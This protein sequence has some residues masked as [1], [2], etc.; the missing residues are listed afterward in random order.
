MLTGDVADVLAERLDGH[1]HVEDLTGAVHLY[2]F[3]AE[4]V[5][6]YDDRDLGSTPP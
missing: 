3:A 5:G 6:Q 1:R 2:S 4:V